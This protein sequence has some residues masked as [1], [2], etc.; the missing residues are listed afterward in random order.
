MDDEHTYNNF[1]KNKLIAELLQY[2]YNFKLVSIE[3]D[4][5]AHDRDFYSLRL[6]S[7]ARDA[8]FG[9]AQHQVLAQRFM[10]QYNAS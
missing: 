7:P 3:S 2:K 8:H 10:E 6:D 1:C 4:N 5:L 9:P